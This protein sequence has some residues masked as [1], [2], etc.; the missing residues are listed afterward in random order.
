MCKNSI[1]TDLHSGTDEIL[2]FPPLTSPY[3]VRSSPTLFHL[4]Y[5]RGCN[6]F[7]TQITK[8]SFCILWA[9]DPAGQSV[10]KKSLRQSFVLCNGRQPSPPL[11]NNAKERENTASSVSLSCTAS[12][13]LYLR[14][15]LL[16]GL[17]DIEQPVDRSIV[18]LV[19]K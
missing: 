11:G 2:L 3:P 10:N 4:N 15:M 17:V 5:A 8:Y 12:G 19:Q 13:M 14:V 7:F 16:H 6:S 1:R 18:Q 9:H